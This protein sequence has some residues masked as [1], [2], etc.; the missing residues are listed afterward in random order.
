MG[1]GFLARKEGNRH[2]KNLMEGVC[3][4]RSLA[5]FLVFGGWKLT[6]RERKVE[7]CSNSALAAR[8][9]SLSVF[10]EVCNHQRRHASRSRTSVISARGSR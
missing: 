2:G 8:Q 9:Y 4:A 3:C 6:Y 10:A 1:P 5:V 7:Y